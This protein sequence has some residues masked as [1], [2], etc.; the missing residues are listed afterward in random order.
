MVE[1]PD[2][3]TYRRSRYH[4]RKTKEKPDPK[5]TSDITPC[6][7]PED[8]PTPAEPKLP[9]SPATAKKTTDNK[10]TIATKTAARL[11]RIRRPPSV[12]ERLRTEMIRY[13]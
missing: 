11:Q 4:L 1:T 8:Q 7:G 10:T 2:G 6:R 5:E 3:D 9:S 12:S 13:D